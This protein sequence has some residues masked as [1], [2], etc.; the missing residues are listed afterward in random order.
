MAT[1]LVNPLEHRGVSSTWSPIQNWL[2][3]VCFIIL[4][5]HLLRLLNGMRV[6]ERVAQDHLLAF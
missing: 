1:G 2:C 6:V 3:V 5:L 4:I